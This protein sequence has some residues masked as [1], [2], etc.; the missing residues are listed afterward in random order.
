MKKV[1][2]Q[3]QRL[4]RSKR[5]A[6]KKRV[7]IGNERTAKATK[8]KPYDNRIKQFQNNSGFQANQGRFFQKSCR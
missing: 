1:Q 3:R 4:A 5:W 8:V 7:Y 2:E 6:D